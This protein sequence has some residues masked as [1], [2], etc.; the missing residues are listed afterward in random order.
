METAPKYNE[1]RPVPG[2]MDY[3]A[4]RDGRIWDAKR[5]RWP[6]L[7]HHSVGYLQMGLR[8]AKGEA[9]KIEKVHR[10]VAAAWLPNP[11]CKYSVNHKDGNK[12]NN[13]VSN[14]EWATMKENLAHASATGL[15]GRRRISAL[16]QIQAHYPKHRR[17]VSGL[18]SYITPAGVFPTLAL[19]AVENQLWPMHILARCMDPQRRGDGWAYEAPLAQAA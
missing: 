19:A 4:S 15:L 12:Q 14:L 5:Q 13:A 11:E 16:A 9:Y 6:K 7:S 18:A 10:L 1:L 2:T 17:R 8:Q 3:Y